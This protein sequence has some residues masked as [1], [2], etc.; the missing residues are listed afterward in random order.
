MTSELL[1][2]FVVQFLGT[3]VV[4]LLTYR[5]FQKRRIKLGEEPTL[6]QYFSRKSTYWIGMVSY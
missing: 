3:G 4:F 1:I 2:N 6:P 5:S